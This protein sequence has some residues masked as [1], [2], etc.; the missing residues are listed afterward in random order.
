MTNDYSYLVKSATAD[1]EQSCT[2]TLDFIA[3]VLLEF[4]SNDLLTSIAVTGCHVSKGHRS[5]RVLI[6]QLSGTGK[7]RYIQGGK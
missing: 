7:M 3:S 2:T 6:V 1:P 4:A 5:G